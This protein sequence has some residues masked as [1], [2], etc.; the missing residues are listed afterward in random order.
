[1]QDNGLLLAKSRGPASSTI[2]DHIMRNLSGLPERVLH[3]GA[4]DTGA[5]SQH[6]RIYVLERLSANTITV[7]WQ[8]ATRCHYSDQT[9]IRC[10]ALARGICA[11]GGGNI[12]RGDV[13]YKPQARRR[14]VANGQAMLLASEVTHALADCV[15][16]PAS[17]WSNGS[18]TS[19]AQARGSSLD[20]SVQHVVRI[21]GRTL[22]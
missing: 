10:T 14:T 4:E 2:W 21:S 1:M 13:V 17:H 20:S 5:S 8:D 6:A 19:A 18:V 12:R 15:G 11:L 22:F 16:A 3:E 9:W 7:L